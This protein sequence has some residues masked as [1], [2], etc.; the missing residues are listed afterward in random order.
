MPIIMADNK[1]AARLEKE[2]RRLGLNT[3]GGTYRYEKVDGSFLT[4]KYAGT[5]ENG[6]N[7]ILVLPD[8]TEYRAP[9]VDIGDGSLVTDYLKR[10]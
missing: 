9:V 2:W 4:G 6:L 8:N 10:L 1:K 7:I 5:S 3:L